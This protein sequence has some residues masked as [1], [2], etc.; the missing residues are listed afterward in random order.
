MQRDRA[1]KIEMEA[2]ELLRRASN[3]PI[4]RSAVRKY[5]KLLRDAFHGMP[6]EFTL[7]MAISMQ[8]QIISQYSE[9]GIG[10]VKIETIWRNK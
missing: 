6:G 3:D 1:Y 2:A 5:I 8:N 4:K 9:F 7:D 10:K